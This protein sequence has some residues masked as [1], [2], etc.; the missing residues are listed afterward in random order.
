VSIARIF[1][2][3]ALILVALLML[4]I[5]SNDFQK[6]LVSEVL[7]LSL[8]ALSFSLLYSAGFISL[9]Q[10]LMFGVGLFTAANTL[11]WG[12][13]PVVALSLAV[14]LGLIFGGATGVILVGADRHQV[15]V[16]TLILNI[17]GYLVALNLRWLTG[18]YQGLRTYVP[19]F[20][21]S[22][23]IAYVSMAFCYILVS[24]VVLLVQASKFFLVVEAMRTNEERLEM[25]GYDT[26]IL[27]IIMFSAS[28]SLASLSGALFAMLNGSA[29][30]REMDL[31]TSIKALVWGLVAGSWNPTLVFTATLALNF[32]VEYSKLFLRSSDLVYGLILSILAIAGRSLSLERIIRVV[33]GG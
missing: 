16:I 27:R 8:L 2:E 13:D 5:V 19:W 18:G 22:P 26:R 10:G 6:L 31:I 24:L 17:I 30:P 9:S 21:E 29:V 1:K 7:A 15:I 20:L 25:I 3:L 11:N 32:L 28:G 14:F 12:V 23:G 4:Y 33:K